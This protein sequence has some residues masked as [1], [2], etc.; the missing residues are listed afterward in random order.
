[1]INNDNDIDEF[2][3]DRRII[4]LLNAKCYDVEHQEQLDQALLICQM[5]KYTP[6]IVNIYEKR[7]M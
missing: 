4:S 3:R 5:S 2:E 6:G 7:Q 1:L